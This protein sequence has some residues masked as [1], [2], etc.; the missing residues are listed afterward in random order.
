MDEIQRRAFMKGAAIGALAFSVGGA[1]VMLTPR[2]AQAQNVP[3]RTLTPEQAATL[4]AMGEALV[5]GAKDAG[6]VNFVDQ[7]LSIPAEQALLEARIMNVRPP[8]ANFYRSALGAIEGASQAKFSKAFT[9]LTAAEQ[10]D[11][12]DLMRQNKLDGWKGPGSP[13]VYFLLAHRRGRRRLRHHGWLRPSRRALSAAYRTDAELV[14]SASMANEKVD[15]VIVGAG[16][17][18]SVYAA[19]LAKAGKK[20]VLLEFGSRLAARRSDQLGFL[21]P[22]GQ[23]GRPAVPARRQESVRLCLSGRLGCRRRGAALLRQLPAPDAE[24][25]QGQEHLRQGARLADRL[26]RHR[27][28]LGQGRRRRRRLRRRQGRGN[29]AAGGKTLS[30]AADEDVSG[31]RRLEERI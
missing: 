10:H 5:P 24:R 1:E 15:V 3:L 2:Q 30:D 17:S 11:F 14:R 26:R 4:G 8:Y 19:V 7:Q 21:G 6:V 31:R 29:L 16:A 20:V 12:I 28:I 18:G 25:L 22:P 13:F 23:A 27:A 9:A